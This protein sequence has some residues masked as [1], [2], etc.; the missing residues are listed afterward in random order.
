MV[1]AVDDSPKIWR[2]WTAQGQFL[3]F[4]LSISL[5][6]VTPLAASLRL[7]F[8]LA[9]LALAGYW[10]TRGEAP[11]FIAFCLWL[12][13]ATP[14]IRRLVDLR[15]GFTEGSL[16]MIAPYAAGGLALLMV[17]RFLMARQVRGQIALTAIFLSTLYGLLLALLNGKL[18]AGT[19]DYLRWTVPPA[20]AAYIIVN[21]TSIVEIS[22]E[23]RRCCV[24]ALPLMSL[25]GLYQFVAPPPWDAIWMVGSKMES[26]GVPEP[27]LIRVFSTLNSPGSCAY[28][29]MAF[30]LIV[31]SSRG[32]SRFGSL[33]LGAAALAV[34]L[35]RSAWLALAA[36][37]LVLL[38]I[39]SWRVRTAILAAA[40]AAVLLMP[41]AFVVPQVGQLLSTR[42][43]SVTE[44]S[45]DFSAADRSRKYGQF[46]TEL[47]QKPLGSG[48]A[49][50]GAY[51]SYQGEGAR[52]VI[53]GALIEIFLA[54]GV[55][56][57]CL[58]CAGIAAMAIGVT[59]RASQDDTDFVIACRTIM[60][61]MTLALTSGTTT[62]GENGLLFWLAAG[63]VLGSRESSV[64]AAHLEEQPRRMQRA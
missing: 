23:I 12:F 45:R 24:I 14:F 64:S 7:F 62:V 58:Y 37:L 16:L 60:V 47:G 17:P 39:G 11:K 35:V 25:Y 49:V 32:Y 19:F 10:F 53:D 26:I 34:T 9:G 57:G 33:I 27:Y 2:P 5:L 50:A 40:G 41:V 13:V 61:A 6:A 44:L 31:L 56:G 38:I 63:L 46:V 29:L 48:L 43:E 21:R 18:S 4:L 30:M 52:R 42:L 55:I 20:I 59:F 1:I 51:Q 28:Y 22:N 54:L 8:P 3:L 36:S 15:A